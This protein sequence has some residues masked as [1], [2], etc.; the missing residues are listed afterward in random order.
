MHFNTK[1]ITYKTGEY[2][3]LDDRYGNPSPYFR[4]VF[5]LKENV[6]KATLLISSMGCFK[7]YLN[8]K[9]IDND[10]LS[11]GWV[12]YN[13]KMP[14]VR[15]DI[16]ETVE[17]ENAIGVV[18]GDGW[19]IG[20]V[21][22]T[23]TFKRNSYCDHLELTAQ[24][25]IE[26]QNGTT[27]TIE[28]DSTWKATSGEIR[29][30]DIYMGEYIDNR[31]S[32]GNF[33]VFSYND[34]KWDAA[35]EVVFRFTRSIYLEEVTLPP[36]VVKHRFKPTL[37]S[38]N[39][40]TYLYDVSQ[41][42]SGVLNCLFKG[43]RDTKVVIRHGEILLDN[44]LYTE[45]LRKAEATD[46][47]ILSGD[48]EER[49]RPIFTFHGFRYA[50]ICIIGKAEILDVTAEAMYTDLAEAGSFSCSDPIVSKIYQ[51]ALWGQRDNFLNVPTDCPQRD[52]R[53]GWT[54][55]AQVFCKSAMYNMDCKAFYEKYLS[56][57][58]DAQLG[59][60]I[61]PAVAPLPHFG[62]HSYVGHVPA[63]GWSEAIA[64][65]P[66]YHYEMYGDRTVVR[67]Y[68][69]PLK[70]L[71]DYYES[72]CPE[73]VRR[74]TGFAYSD[75]L[76]LDESDKDVISTLYYAR[77]S[78]V[79][80]KLCGVIGDYEEE[81]YL[82]LY[83]HIKTAF[84]KTF[85]TTDGTIR[86]DTQSVY[87]IAYKF[88]IIDKELALKNLNRK[89]IEDDGKLTCGF[90]GIRFLLPA[91]CDLG[92]VD[93]AY[94]LIT[95]TEYPGWGY[96]VVNGATTIWERWD[97]YTAENGIKPGMN[98]FNHYSFGSCTEWMYEYCLGIQPD[99]K[100]PGF[101]KVIFNPHFDPT[102]KITWA[103]GHYDT[104]FGRINVQW[105]FIGDT[106]KYTVTVPAEILVEFDFNEFRIIDETV[107][108]NNYVFTLKAQ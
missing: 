60:G 57:I 42:I 107:E 31:M 35:E 102:H 24:I 65:I 67:N 36:I 70:R 82:C 41:N 13:K 100:N 96:S 17:K 55:D 39:N 10:H 71:L 54:A 32:V 73:Y 5:T 53:L 104:K 99:F 88:G 61:I 78:Y 48:G 69:P 46:T 52:E 85:V 22:S 3:T 50:E 106:V 26:Y 47:Y 33:S 95:N 21:G 34:E 6:K 62:F 103:K 76:S 86:S 59:N 7:A 77:A 8:G 66:Y 87:L 89:F 29:R 94:R 92:K 75:W 4:K 83:D 79:A 97:S 11:P 72:T 80:A 91:L 14:F 38:K 2:K 43:E 20:H 1:W 16:T 27:E 51:N 98:S 56:D 105:E 101:K 30:S 68:L 18:L 9:P 23:T 49:F 58:R 28:T 15:Y 93:L 40:N 37:L 63:A 74:P 44:K 64:E 45:N 19:A 90:L 84:N 108:K 12:D 25:V 81:R